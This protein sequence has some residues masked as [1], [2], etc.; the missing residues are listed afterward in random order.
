MVDEEEV[1]LEL[2]YDA[3]LYEAA[4]AERLLARFERLLAAAVA[5]PAAP[6]DEL[7]VAT[8]AE[9]VELLLEHYYDPLYRHSEQGRT[10]ALEVDST[11]PAQAAAE[12]AAWAETRDGPPAAERDR[13]PV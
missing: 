10:Y 9:L 4:T 8:E 11:D 2:E 1:R 6:L 13:G 7:P 3:D 12:I 5:D